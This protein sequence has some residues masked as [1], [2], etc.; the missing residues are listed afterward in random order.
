MDAN[1]VKGGESRLFRLIEERA[2]PGADV[3]SI[4]R[5]IWDLF[6]DT[7]A[8]VFTDL[9]GF[10]RRVAEFGIIQ[11]LQEIHAQRRLFLPIIAAHDGILLKEEADSMLLVFRRPDQAVAC[12][13]AMQRASKTENDARRP[14]DR[15]LLCVGIGYGRVLRIADRDV[16]GQEV[17]AASKLGEDIAKAGQI[18]VTDAV[19]SE[20]PAHSFEPIEVEV[21]GS[22]R[23]FELRY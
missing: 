15:V 6:G 7:A 23:N 16:Y 9:T 14:E 8:I 20:L 19:R 4:D 1:D 5:R 12:S 17:N 10:S 3:E 22:L 13:V 2:A 21:A 11:F 18:L